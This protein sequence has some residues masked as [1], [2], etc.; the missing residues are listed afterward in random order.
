MKTIRFF[1][2]KTGIMFNSIALNVL[3][4][5]QKYIFSNDVTRHEPGREGGGGQGAI[6]LYTMPCSPKA[7]QFWSMNIL[8]IS[9]WIG[10]TRY[11]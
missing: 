4:L 8:I 6:T 11:F 10:V 1:A 7:G 3:S 2:K 9:C 5:S